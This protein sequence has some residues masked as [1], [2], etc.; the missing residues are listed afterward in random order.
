MDTSIKILEIIPKII[1]PIVVIILIFIFRKYIA[2]F[3]IF[4]RPKVLKIG[5]VQIEAE[6]LSKNILNKF[7]NSIKK[8]N[9]IY[10]RQYATRF[11]PSYMDEEIAYYVHIFEFLFSVDIKLENVI[12]WNMIANYY[13]YKDSHKSKHAYE[14][15]ISLDESDS[16]SHAN[17]GMYYLLIENNKYLAKLYFIKAINL[18]EDKNEPCPIGHLGLSSV[19]KKLGN[20]NDEKYYCEIAKN[21]FAAS[22]NSDCTDFWS[23]YGLGWCYGSGEK[24]I[25]KA[26]EFTKT[27]IDLKSDFLIARYNLACYYAIKGDLSKSIKALKSICYPIKEFLRKSVV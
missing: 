8:I 19:A 22:A 25:E 6:D 1:W 24:D 21:E 10:P 17:L 18:A 15:A 2:K 9:T 4:F 7:E 27:A 23:F 26:I 5:P 13:F 11:L 3:F 14:Q 20:F 12:M 16:I